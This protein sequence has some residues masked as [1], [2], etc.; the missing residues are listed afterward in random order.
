MRCRSVRQQYHWKTFT[1]LRPHQFYLQTMPRMLT[2]GGASFIG[3]H[4]CDAAREAGYAVTVLDN[5]SSGS[6]ANLPQG[7]RLEQLDLRDREE[8][9]LAVLRA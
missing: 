5:L 8:V 7:V 9:R 4:V 2:T 1:D 6:V 3:S